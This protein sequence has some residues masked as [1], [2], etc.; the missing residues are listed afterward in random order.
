MDEVQF[1]Q[2]VQIE[3]STTSICCRRAQFP[4]GVRFQLRWARVV[5]EDTDLAAPSI[6]A[7]IPSLSTAVLARQEEQ[8][9]RAWRRLLA[10]E[11]SERP[12][13]LSLRGVN[14]AG[15]R[16]SNVSVADCRFA[17]ADNL[18]KLR[19]DS[20]SLVRVPIGLGFRG[21]DWDW[22]QVIADERDWRAK[23]RFGLWHW[24]APIRPNWIDDQL[25]GLVEPSQIARLYRALRKGVEDA[26]DEPGAA[27]FYYGEME[28]R[29]RARP[30]GNPDGRAMAAGRVERGILTAYWLVS[31]YGPRGA[32]GDM[33]HRC[34]CASCGRVSPDWFRRPAAPGLVLD[35]SVVC[36]PRRLVP[37]RQ[38]GHVDCTGSTAARCL[39]LTG[40]VLL[41]WPCSPSA[42]D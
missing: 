4:S 23:Q 5:L 35:E 10:D 29:R 1:A 42:A 3:V 16:L 24:A 28:M 15:L 40:P 7:G 30:G 25:P 14:V 13:L 31:G 32:S 6:I 27:D 33:A 2:P 41:G 12:Q 21:W 34:H 18:D 8:I 9:A 22:R 39:R 36:V 17:D 37:H 19:L 20:G 11:I 26:K 38:R